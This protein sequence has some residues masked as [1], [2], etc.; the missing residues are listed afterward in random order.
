MVGLG[1]KRNFVCFGVGLISLFFSSLVVFILFFPVSF[2]FSFF[3]GGFPFNILGLKFVQGCV[4]VAVSA[5]VVWCVNFV[6][7]WYVVCWLVWVVWGVYWSCPS[8]FLLVICCEFIFVNFF[9][10][11]VLLFWWYLPILA[12]SSVVLVGL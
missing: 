10:G 7:F 2:F 5:G 9:P 12:S 3:L 1:R 4:T 11:F 8:V 6:L